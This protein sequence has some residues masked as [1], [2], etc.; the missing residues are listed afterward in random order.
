MG[1]HH[2]LEQ[3]DEPE[4]AD[5]NPKD[6]SM[7]LLDESTFMMGEEGS[8]AVIPKRDELTETAIV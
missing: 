2:V 3:A 7:A 5:N 6:S 1:S 4:E 8:I